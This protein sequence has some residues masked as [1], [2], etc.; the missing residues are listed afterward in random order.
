MNAESTFQRHL[1]YYCMGLGLYLISALWQVFTSGT[2]A[3][4]FNATLYAAALVTLALFKLKS[5]G[6]RMTDLWVCFVPLYLIALSFSLF[7]NPFIKVINFVALPIGLY[8]FVSN[9]HERFLH[10]KDVLLIPIAS[11]I[12]PFNFIAHSVVMH[13]K[14]L[15]VAK[16]V[17]YASEKNL[18]GVMIWEIGQDSQDAKTSLMDALR[19]AKSDMVEEN[20]AHDQGGSE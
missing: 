2:A 20:T 5:D 19:Q 14:S 3:L 10:L 1:P 17:Q 15:L 8:I 6:R 16:K 12:V 13:R 7:E 4:G 11:L 18:G 9:M